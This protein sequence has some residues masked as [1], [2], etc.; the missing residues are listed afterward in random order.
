MLTSFINCV[1]K[2]VLLLLFLAR[3][4]TSATT[5]FCAYP[6]AI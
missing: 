6:V 4:R 3:A 5:A 1:A 2:A